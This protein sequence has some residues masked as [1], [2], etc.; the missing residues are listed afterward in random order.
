ML[1]AAA[2][3]QSAADLLTKEPLNQAAGFESWEAAHCLTPQNPGLNGPDE[4]RVLKRRCCVSQLCVVRDRENLER[5][6][7]PRLL[8]SHPSK[9][10]DLNS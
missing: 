2:A 6:V 7:A 8:F 1:L 3:S 10:T 5:S 9:V 4:V